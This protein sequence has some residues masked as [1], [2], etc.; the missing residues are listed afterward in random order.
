MDDGTEQRDL[1]SLQ[2][3]MNVV[4]FG[5]TGGTGQYTIELA[6]ELGHQVTAVVRRPE[7]LQVQ[8]IQLKVLQGD[9]TEGASL[10]A[11]LAGK[12]AVMSALGVGNSLKPTTLYSRGS[13]NII[14]AMKK[15]G[16][17]RFIGVTA[18]G[19]FDH[20]NDRLMLKYLV[21]P[22]LK[23]VLKNPYADM[24][25]MEALVQQCDLDW[26]IVRPA[27]L[28][29]GPHTGEYRT[30]VEGNVPGGSTISRKDLADFM[31][32]QLDNASTFGKAVGIAY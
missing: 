7:A 8:H 27:R 17:R 21:K 9:V 31:V 10:A 12:H 1:R 15:A 20:A 29:D 19:Y 5:G 25:R 14:E 6:L 3:P 30:V 24:R 13:R 4:V 16:L 22:M 26:T 28:T 32:K 23:R 2:P 18:G 11:A